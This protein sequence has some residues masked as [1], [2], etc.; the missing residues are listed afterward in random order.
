MNILFESQ[1]INIPASSHQDNS[2]MPEAVPDIQQV[3]VQGH[4]KALVEHVYPT[5]NPGSEVPRKHRDV[6]EARDSEISMNDTDFDEESNSVSEP[7]A[8]P[9]G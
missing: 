8:D 2:Q 1:E 7:Q 6:R 9:P 5:L 3:T 4:R